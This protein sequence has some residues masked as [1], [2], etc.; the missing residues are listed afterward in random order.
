[1]HTPSGDHFAVAVYIF[2]FRP[3]KWG[4]ISIHQSVLEQFVQPKCTHPLVS[5]GPPLHSHPSSTR[6]GQVYARAGQLSPEG[7]CISAG[8]KSGTLFRQ[9]LSNYRWT[10][11]MILRFQRVWVYTLAVLDGAAAIA[12][13]SQ[14]PGYPK[15]ETV[16]G[17]RMIP[18]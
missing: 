4:I 5:L 11:A 1:M 12:G 7:A 14:R 2:K 6:G 17:F 16:V 8:Q 18:G 10:M 15:H 13:S 3:G 9:W